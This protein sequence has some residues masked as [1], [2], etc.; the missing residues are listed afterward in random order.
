MTQPAD[1]P[2]P[3]PQPT[4]Q[5]RENA[6]IRQEIAERQAREYAQVLEWATTAFGPGWLPRCR[7]FLV[8]V[9]EEE[10]VRY[11]G[12]RPKAAATVYTVRNKAGQDRHFTVEDG[13]VIEH[14]SYQAGFGSMLLEPHPSR[15]FE[16]RGQWCRIHRYSL[17]WAHYDLY[18][19]KS[20]E[21]LAERR[22]TRERRKQER[23]DKRWA[24]QNPLLAW[25]ERANQPDT[26]AEE[27]RRSR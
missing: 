3:Q 8:E 2:H 21:Q 11:T 14:A 12:E 18:A 26:P 23:E 25:A 6:R 7:H 17:C 5:D 16:H 19:P 22:A 13:K 1:P 4:D 10:R 20:A 15:G 24:E 9:D 27:E